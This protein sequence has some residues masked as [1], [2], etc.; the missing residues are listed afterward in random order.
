[1]ELCLADERTDSEFLSQLRAGEDAA[2]RRLVAMYRPV[3]RTILTDFP[4]DCNERDDLEQAFW[5]T[6][7]AKFDRFRKEKPGDSLRGWLRTVARNLVFDHLRQ[8]KSEAAAAV[9]GSDHQRQLGAIPE[10]QPEATDDQERSEML[11]VALE[12]VRAEVS[13]RDFENFRRSVM[14]GEPLA[15]VALASGMRSEALRMANARV[16]QKLRQQLGELWES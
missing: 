4:L 16:R 12:R 7:F 11:G 1:M 15:A 5:L 9:G 3:L 2:R 14:R 13:G 8:R 6:V 10:R